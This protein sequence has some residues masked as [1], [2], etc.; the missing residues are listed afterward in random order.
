MHHT[1][2]NNWNACVS[3][4]D[5]IYILG[6]LIHKGDGED[7]NKLLKK[8]NGK[9]YLI[10][11]NHDGYVDEKAFDQSYFE[12]IKDYYVLRYDHQKFVL[13]HYPILE[14]DGFFGGSIHLHGH[15]HNSRKDPTQ[16]AR[17]EALGERAFNVG[18]DVNDFR[19]ISIN[20]IMGRIKQ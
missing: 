10:R 7:A 1:L 12:W 18:V 8:L 16:L 2:I 3:K 9:K 19:P 11:G 14:W 20:E 15:V 4:K 6:D 13:F 5:E 17:L